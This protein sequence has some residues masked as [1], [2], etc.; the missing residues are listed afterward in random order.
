MDENYTVHEIIS[1][2]QQKMGHG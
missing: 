1:L 2:I